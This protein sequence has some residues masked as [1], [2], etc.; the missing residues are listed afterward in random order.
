M[1]GLVVTDGSRAGAGWSRRACRERGRRVRRARGTTR[2]TRVPLGVAVVL[3]TSDSAAAGRTVDV[4]LS[5][6]QIELFGALPAGPREVVLEVSLSEAE[7]ASLRAVIVRRALS[8]EG[9]TL[10]AVRLVPGAAPTTV[11]RGP[12][13]TSKAPSAA[14]ARMGHPRAW[15]LCD[16]CVLLVRACSSWPWRTAM[17]RRPPRWSPGSGAWPASSARRRPRMWEATRPC[18]GVSPACTEP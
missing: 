1:D 17:P 4:S 7:P 9:R 11:Y 13:L 10:L 15:S 3:R 5:G 14:P 8:A 16:S 2:R 18:S 12:A 6:I